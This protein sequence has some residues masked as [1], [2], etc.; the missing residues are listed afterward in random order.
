MKSNY[1]FVY[2]TLLPD[3]KHP[4]GILLADNAEMVGQGLS[5]GKLFDLGEYPGLQ[6]SEKHQV[7][8]CVY[9]II[10]EELWTELDWYEGYTGNENDEYIR[11][12]EKI[13][14]NDGQQIDAWV[15]FFQ[16]S[17]PEELHIKDGDYL[18]FMN[19]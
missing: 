5:N 19:N 16:P 18:D 1:L 7:K 6:K 13:Q 11:T 12:V 4:M 3:F 9:K 15:Y 17:L 2:G 14:M 8:G 10:N